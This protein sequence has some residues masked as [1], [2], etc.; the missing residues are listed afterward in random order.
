MCLLGE[1]LNDFITHYEALNYNVDS[2]MT[3]HRRLTRSISGPRHIQLRFNALGRAFNLKL[4]QGSPSLTSDAVVM[5]D[6]RPISHYKSLIYHGVDEGDN[7]SIIMWA[8]TSRMFIYT[9]DHSV[10]VH[11]DV[12][13]G[14]FTGQIRTSQD[15]YFIE[16]SS[17]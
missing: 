10:R 1:A 7:I 2:L 8:Y 13:R 6:D 16:P 5:V 15:I 3:D 14:I 4:Y 17:R 12:A 9:D 11:G